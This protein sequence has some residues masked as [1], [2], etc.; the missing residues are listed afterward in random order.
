M[1]LV[2][3]QFLPPLHLMCVLCTIHWTELYRS[4]RALGE[5]WYVESI[6]F[7][8]VNYYCFKVGQPIHHK[9]HQ[10]C[11]WLKGQ[12]R[13]VHKIDIYTI[14]LYL[15]NNKKIQSYLIRNKNKFLHTLQGSTYNM[16]TLWTHRQNHTQNK[17]K[18]LCMDL[19]C[20]T[21][22]PVYSHLTLKT[23]IWLY[24]LSAN[25]EPRLINYLWFCCPTR[26]AP[27]NVY[28]FCR[29]R[30]LHDVR[31]MIR[32]TVYYTQKVK[33]MY[34]DGSIWKIVQTR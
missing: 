30:L 19:S 2:S 26:T 6:V 24:W 28:V 7:Y 14:Y 10:S 32:I 27:V 22:I 16:T 29:E 34:T 11:G 12:S 33:R 17:W 23:A 5:K 15:N 21:S 3:M 25:T 31:S 20:T 1:F 13:S 4:L 8:Y 18:I 9:S